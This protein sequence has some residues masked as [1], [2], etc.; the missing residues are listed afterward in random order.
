MKEEI[1]VVDYGGQYTQ[2][3]ARRVRE[4]GVYSRIVS[5][6]KV[7]ARDIARASGIINSGG[8]KSCIDSDAPHYN[9]QLFVT[10]T[11]SLDICYGMQLRAN[12]LPGGEVVHGAKREYGRNLV[13]IVERNDT[14]YKG[15][16]KR[17]QCWM[18]HG[19]K[20][21][22]IPDGY[23]VT[24]KTENGIIASMS[25]PARN[26]YSVQFHPEVTHTPDGMDILA[27][28]VYRIAGCKKGSWDLGKYVNTILN[29]IGK[30]VKGRDVIM[31]ASGGVDS[32]VA[33]AL[34]AKAK[35][36]GKDVGRVYV[37]HIDNGLM[38]TNESKQVVE[39]LT[40]LKGLENLIFEDASAYFLDK[41]KGVVN[42]TRKRE[43][44]G[45]AFI[46]VQNKIIRRLKLSKNTM[47][48]QG[49]LYTD[50]IESGKGVGTHASVIKKHH[51]VAS[52]YVLKKRKKGLV[53][54]PLRE[55]FKDESRRIGEH[56][57]LPQEIVWRQPFPGPGLGIRA[58]GRPLTKKRLDTLRRATDILEEEIE[59][60]CLDRKIWQYFPALLGTKAV[61]VKGDAGTHQEI[62]AIRAVT[63]KDGMTADWYRFP[64]RV[65][66]K[67]SRRLM[68]EVPGIGRVLYDIGSKPPETIEFE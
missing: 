5:C 38:R 35:E 14:L 42:P 61:G 50:L 56:L 25:N 60:A 15:L 24:A 52:P 11:P 22:K 63:S 26:S 68:N 46:D 9:P 40:K 32:T 12:I 66:D 54:E 7:T 39:Y 2:N 33:A 55:L 44:I 62:C 4:L 37:V 49:T 29:D 10:D 64:H 8:P 13:T 53:I 19:D 45:D 47:L 58:I 18:S 6:D 23:R 16:E 28:F 27:N 43:I 48:C 1:L 31:F 17:I 21:T 41:L 51:N 30:S 34:L 57:G 67:I 36:K 20:V 3:I 59:K 65:M